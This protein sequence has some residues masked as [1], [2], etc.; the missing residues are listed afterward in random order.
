MPGQKRNLETPDETFEGDLVR[1]GMVRLGDLTVGRTVQQPGWRWSVH[2]RPQV[3]GT[4]CQ[5]R[6]V[7]IL[8]QGQFRFEWPDGSTLD[9]APNDVYDVG[10]GHDGWIVGHEEAL[11]I[12]WEGLRTWSTPMGVGE[13]VLASLLFTDVVD[14]TATG[15]SLGERAWSDLLA[16]HNEMVRRAVDRF[17]GHEV[18]TTGDG[19]LISFDGAERAIR[20][21][22]EISRGATT[23]G[24]Y[25]RS[26]IHTGE[27]EVVANDVRGIAVHEAARIASAAGPDEILVSEVTRALAAGSGLTFGPGVSHQLRGLEGARVLYPVAGFA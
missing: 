9:V 27:V 25:I 4:W 23:L 16:R 26:G 13:R 8:L 10:P 12:E 1:S 7:G 21:A 5:A 14:S 2:M 6:H 24:L 20:C 22:M 15:V 19:F 18:A 11:S 17:R 3:G